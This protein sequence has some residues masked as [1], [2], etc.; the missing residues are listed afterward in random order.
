MPAEAAKMLAIVPKKVG[1]ASLVI[2]QGCILELHLPL[3]S[4]CMMEN[5][6]IV[7]GFVIII[8]DIATSH[9]SL[10]SAATYGRYTYVR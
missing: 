10:P 2:G 6:D 7:K 4:A 5:C 9:I 8:D 3:V 1:L